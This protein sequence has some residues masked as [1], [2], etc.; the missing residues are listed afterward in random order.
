M[1]QIKKVCALVAQHIGATPT[2]I[3]STL[4]IACSAVISAVLRSG[5]GLSRVRE[6]YSVKAIKL[7][8]SH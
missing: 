7:D 2:I 3:A 1:G 6:E 5:R 4:I 8:E